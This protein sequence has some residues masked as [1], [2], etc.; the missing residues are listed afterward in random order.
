MTE[1]DLPPTEDLLRVEAAQRRFDEVVASI[2]DAT[3]RRP[4]ALPGWTVGH[5]LTHV[6]RNAD[7]HVR[8]AEAAVRGEVIEQYVGG[9][10]GRAA[11]IDAGA[12]RSARELVDDVRAS[13]ERLMATWLALPGEA[14][15]GMTVDVSGTERS[16]R[17]L[18][19][20]RWQELEVHVVD[21]GL[22]PTHRDWSDDFVEAFFP[23]R[24]SGALRESPGIEL[25]AS[26][27]FRDDR[28]ELAWLFGRAERADLPRLSP[29]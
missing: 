21:L 16:V 9:W 22:G 24:R 2:D 13:G 18:V 27:E 8:R 11:E 6:A 28:E 19:S 1:R 23:R 3:A 15:C 29:F 4:T 26:T 20:R 14:W 7:S 17:A 12:H 10:E 5:V 25:P